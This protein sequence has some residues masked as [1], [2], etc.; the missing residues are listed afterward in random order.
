MNKIIDKSQCVCVFLFVW[1]IFNLNFSF[2]MAL[3][4][5]QRHTDVFF[6]NFNEIL[7][8]HWFE[9]FIQIEY[10]EMR[11]LIWSVTA[12]KEMSMLREIW[13]RNNSEI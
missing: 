1:I 9:L 5:E 3:S 13:M 7:D 4:I 6:V 11:R 12:M 10:M 2:K 8:E